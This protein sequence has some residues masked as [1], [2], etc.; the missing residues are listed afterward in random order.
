MIQYLLT[1]SISSIFIYISKYI[2]RNQRWILFF[3]ALFIPCFLAGIRSEIIGT[4]VN[5]YLMPIY[6]AAEKAGNFNEYLNTSWFNI[7]R[8][9]SVKEYEIGFITVIYVLVKMFHSI[10]V[11]KFFIQFLIIYPIYFALK[12]YGEKTLIWIGMLIYF[13]LFFNQ[14]L[15]IMRQYISMSFVFLAIVGFIK[16]NDFKH[17]VIFQL[18]ALTF[19]SSSLIGL[20]IFFIY[21]FL[22][23]NEVN[24]ITVLNK[25]VMYISILGLLLL[26]SPTL[27][28]K[29]LAQI[30][31]NS[32]SLY[33]KGEL[34]FMPN[35]IIIRLP[36]LIL[37]LINWNKMCKKSEYFHF[38]FCML[39]FTILFAQL[40]GSSQFG[41]RI[42]IYFAVFQIVLCIQLCKT[43]GRNQ[44]NMVI[45]NI[46]IIA[47]YLFYWWFYYAYMG[48]DATVPFI[49]ISN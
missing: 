28:S 8:Y 45:L 25:R 48:M 30:G 24:S 37:S 3:I 1:F 27:I 18:I 7:Y 32:Y 20:G 41:A 6:N 22:Y 40:A 10:F 35:Q 31:L 11:V 42:A 13:L 23:R 14:S 36:L 47:Y 19:H 4:D 15:N 44:I 49:S 33:I 17:Y 2:K 9:N 12:K 46:G 16:T 5:V 29:F 21:K 39:I 43:I 34:T 38:Y 26:L